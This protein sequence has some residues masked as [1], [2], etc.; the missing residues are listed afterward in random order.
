MSLK[1]DEHAEIKTADNSAILFVLSG[2]VSLSC[3]DFKNKISE[4]MLFLAP[5]SKYELSTE[6][7]TELVKCEIVKNVLTKISQWLSP[8]S[9]N[10]VE[11]D[12]VY[13]TL[14]VKYNLK[15]FLEFFQQY[16]S[17]GLNTSEIVEWKQEGLFLLL[18]NSYSKRELTG[19]FKTILGEN[20]DFKEFVYANYYSVKNLQEFADLA[21]CSL[22]VFCRD[23][24]K[25]FGESAYQWMLKRKSQYV[26]R[27]ILS[28]SI[29]FQELADKYQFSSQAHF[30]KFCKQ[31]YNLTPRELRSSNENYRMNYQQL[32]N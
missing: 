15:K 28:T 20:M 29:P 19:F 4:E 22:S 3:I 5:G 14:P 31:R 8:I 1:K 10:Q 9:E 21:K 17:S 25:N 27:D 12:E 30:T 18:K 24:K 13:L 2:K 26:L 23:F 11:E 16:Y 6:E 7:E 32:L